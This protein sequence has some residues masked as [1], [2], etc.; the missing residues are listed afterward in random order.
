MCSGA[1]HIN[2]IHTDTGTSDDFE[3][4]CCIEKICCH[5]RL[6]TD[7]ESFIVA[8]DRLKL[9]RTQTLFL[10]YLELILQKC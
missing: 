7:N 3:F 10:M 1:L 6:R 2:I 9:V 8:D 4:L 5:F